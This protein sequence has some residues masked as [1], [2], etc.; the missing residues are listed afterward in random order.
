MRGLRRPRRF[1]LHTKVIAAFAVGAALVSA[2][3]AFST[4][5]FVRQNLV[6]QQI[7][8][9]LRQTY[10]DARLVK[11]ELGAPS[12]QIGDALASVAP[13]NGGL[14][15]VYHGG[16]WYSSSASVS[17]KS[18]PASF[19]H[20]VID[21]NAAEQRVSLD[22][23]PVLVVGIPIPSLGIEYFE[24]HPLAELASTL[25]VLATVLTI[26]ALATTVGGALAG[27]WASRR[28][29]RPLNEVVLAATDI[30]GGTLDRRVP[31]DPDLQPLVESFNLMVG[32][33]QD[34]IERDARFAADVT[35]ELRSPLTTIEAS[36]ELLAS[37]RA[38]LPDEAA[39]AVRTL[40]F[41][42]ERFA[43]MVQGLLELAGADAGAAAEH[44]TDVPL[45]AL[46]RATAAGRRPAVPVSV[47][48]DARDVIVRGDKLRL[49]Q[50]LVNLLDNA[51]TYGGGAVGIAVGRDGSSATLTVQDAGPGVPPD[52]RERVF[53]RFYRGEASGRRGATTGTG[54]GLSLVA[55]HVRLHGGTVSLDERPGGGARVTITLPVAAP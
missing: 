13:A 48:S 44:F 50:V 35:H 14:A 32:A 46:V 25:R 6:G 20:V 36:V 8:S 54:L 39:L 30:A 12:A 5:Y 19:T 47:A 22:N 38:T 40:G 24:E 1:G 16:T 15:F 53:E 31:A 3:L 2:V 18:I 33:L 55:E 17:G 52:E 37:Q 42:V 41:E 10:G 29:V 43:R 21:G 11:L 23:E 9:D 4:F 28:L 26:V 27:W 45:A 7:R 34:R 51:E 49:H